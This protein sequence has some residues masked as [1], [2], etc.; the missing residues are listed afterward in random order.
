MPRRSVS[1]QMGDEPIEILTRRPSKA[2][3][4]REWEKRHRQKK[5]FVSYRGVPQELHENLKKIA[6]DLGVPVGE[7]ARAFLEYGLEACKRGD[8]VLQ[9]KPAIGKFSLFPEEN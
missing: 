2:K 6:N 3:R 4:N 7:V 1:D 9:P 5:G 8:L